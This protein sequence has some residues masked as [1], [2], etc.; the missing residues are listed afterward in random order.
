[1]SLYS[2]LKISIKNHDCSVHGRCA[3][4]SAALTINNV[5]L[6][7]CILFVFVSVVSGR[8]FGYSVSTENQ[9]GTLQGKF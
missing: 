6:E 9:S 4:C 7:I 5:N 8:S 3:V 2:I 1:M